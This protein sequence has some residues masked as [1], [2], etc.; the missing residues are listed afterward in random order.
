[1]DTDQAV[2]NFDAITYEKGAA[3][4]KQLVAALG[5]DAFR[6]GLKTYF[7]RHAW[8]NATLSDFLGALGAAAGQSLEAWSK[9]WLQTPSLNTIGARWSS[10][11]GRISAM[12]LWQTAPQQHPALR[13]HAT[14][15]G[16]VTGA[17]DGGELQLDSI[18]VRIDSAVKLVP[19]AVGRATPRL[20]HAN[21]GDHDFALTILDPI[22]LEFA[23]ARLPDLPDA[24]LRQQVWSALWEMV[25]DAR[26]AS[27]TFLDAVRRFAPAETDRGL[28]QA[29]VDR[30]IETLRRYVPAE[31]MAAESEALLGIAMGAM[32]VTEQEDLRLVWARAATA[33]A[34]SAGGIEHLLELVD[35]VWSIDGFE[36]DQQMRWDL[37]IK[38]VAHGLD[39]SS[40]RLET[41]ESRDRSDRGQRSSVRAR[42]ARPDAHSKHAAWERI[43][44]DGYGSDYLTRS[45]IA[46]FQWMH[47]REVLLTFREPFFERAINIH[48]TRD[49]AFAESYVHWLVPD[50][51]AEHEVLEEIG[52]VS[53][54]LGDG[55]V[56]LRRQFDEIADDLA[57]AIR[58]RAFAGDQ[59]QAALGEVPAG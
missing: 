40:D 32:R 46:G 36:P 23:L 16:L 26:L 48:A 13:P 9:A 43:N 58:V 47:Q 37:A 21:H 7:Q 30:A 29:I 25:R 45:A 51:W 20:V 24:L 6:A 12:E 5:D 59:H 2:G 27:P 41:E 53:E 22:S 15:L 8:S 55:S 17:D 11:A 3:V 39:G 38:A 33:I 57:R 54:G 10:D 42:A 14:Y 50:R 19:E 28:V 35:G 4:I 1:D 44:G 34:S 49:H 52:R 18:A 56:L 31:R